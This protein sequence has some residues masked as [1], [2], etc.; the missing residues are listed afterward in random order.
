MTAQNNNMDM[1]NK[2]TNTLCTYAKPYFYEAGIVNSQ[3]SHNRAS[4]RS[5][6]PSCH[7]TRTTVKQSNSNQ[8]IYLHQ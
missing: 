3:C 2:Q 4:K 8:V 5:S 6:V 7:F 1:D